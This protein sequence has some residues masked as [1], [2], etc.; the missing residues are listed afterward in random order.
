MNVHDVLGT[1]PGAT[2]TEIEQAF[3]A[4]LRGARRRPVLG[5]DHDPTLPILTAFRL[6][7]AAGEHRFEPAGV[8]VAPPARVVEPTPGGRR[9]PAAGFSAWVPAAA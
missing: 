8:A 6:A 7:M 5:P 9:L 4:R 1:T 3:V 2:M